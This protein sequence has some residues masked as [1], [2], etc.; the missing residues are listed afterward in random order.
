[1]DTA[2]ENAILN[3]CPPFCRGEEVFED[4]IKSDYFVGYHFK[5]YCILYV[6]F[7]MQQPHY[8]LKEQSLN[9]TVPQLRDSLFVTYSHSIFF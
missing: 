5:K 7:L 6:Y 4:V 1:M 8:K 3:P 9:C 2:N